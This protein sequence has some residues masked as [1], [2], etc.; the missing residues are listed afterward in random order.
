[1]SNAFPVQIELEAFKNCFNVDLLDTFP[2][3]VTFLV[4]RGTFSL[5]LRHPSAL[6][7]V[8]VIQD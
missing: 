6:M 5:L 1:M 8:D 7:V 4:K 3:E 2:D